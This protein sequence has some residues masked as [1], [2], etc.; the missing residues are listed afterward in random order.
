MHETCN[1]N[2]LICKTCTVKWLRHA[3]KSIVWRSITLL[4]CPLHSVLVFIFQPILWQL[5]SHDHPPSLAEWFRGISNPLYL[6][7]IYWVWCCWNNN[8]I[9]IGRI[10]HLSSLN[11]FYSHL[12]L[13][14]FQGRNFLPSSLNHPFLSSSECL[15]ISLRN[16][17][18]KEGITCTLCCPETQ[19]YG[20]YHYMTY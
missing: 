9:A 7:E 1:T 15:T 8:V 17:H 16:F 6:I 12:P 3:T 11:S 14:S 2:S 18:E 4:L 5:I 19:F 20:D 13:Y 10:H